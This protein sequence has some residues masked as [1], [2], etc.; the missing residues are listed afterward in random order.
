MTLQKKTTR[1]TFRIDPALL[2]R[3]RAIAKAFE[4]PVPDLLVTGALMLYARATNQSQYLAAKAN[5]L[6]FDGNGKPKI[7]GELTDEL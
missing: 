3:V 5:Y 7:Q 4:T 1:Y 2:E 6:A